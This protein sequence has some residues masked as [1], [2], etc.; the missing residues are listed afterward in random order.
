MALFCACE[1]KEG[2]Q[3][4]PQRQIFCCPRVLLC[5]WNCGWMWPFSINTVIIGWKRATKEES[6]SAPRKY[7]PAKKKA[8]GIAGKG[9]ARKETLCAS[10]RSNSSREELK[11][12]FEIYPR[13]KVRHMGK[14]WVGI[15]CWF[16]KNENNLNCKWKLTWKVS[17]H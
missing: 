15:V 9:L 13:I 3:N 16:T 6:V 12:S 2:A 4:C 14:K 5:K 17:S 7:N 10:F 1:K 8:R 11:R